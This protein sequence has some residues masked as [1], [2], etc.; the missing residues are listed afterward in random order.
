MLGAAGLVSEPVPPHCAG[1]AGAPSSS[2]ERGEIVR[3]SHFVEPLCPRR[4]P[5]PSVRSLLILVCRE[6]MGMVYVTVA[7]DGQRLRTVSPTRCARCHPEAS[8]MPLT[9]HVSWADLARLLGRQNGAA[10]GR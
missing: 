6:P 2:M 7:F 9:R 3:P 10:L 8:K 4:G 1:Q 5:S